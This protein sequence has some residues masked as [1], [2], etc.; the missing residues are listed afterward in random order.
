MSLALAPRFPAMTQQSAKPVGLSMDG[1]LVVAYAALLPIQIEIAVDFRVAPADLCVLL[2]ALPLTV[3]LR[4]RTKAWSFWHMGILLTFAVGS[5]LAILASGGLSRYLFVNKDLGLLL[6]F[7]TYMVVTSAI[8]EWKQ[9]RLVLQVFVWSVVLQNLVGIAEFLISY[10][11]GVD[12]YFTAYGN[13]RFAGMLLD[14]NANGG[15]LILSLLLCEATSRGPTALVRGW[16]LAFCRLTL[17]LGILLSFSRTAWVSLAIAWLFLLFLLPTRIAV[18]IRAVLAGA[19]ALI[20]GM[21]LAGD[22]FVLYFREMA[23][24][25]ESGRA[26]GELMEKAL[27]HFAHNPVWGGGLGNFIETEGTIVHNTPLWFLADFGLIGLAMFVGFMAWFVIKAWDARRLAPYSEKIVVQAL[28]I[29]HIAML[30]LGMGIEAFYQ[31]H[32]WL[33][34]ALIASS[35]H[36]ATRR[37]YLIE[38]ALSA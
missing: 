28:L 24:R 11:F 12:T 8:T 20:L 29:G 16:W 36:I 33:V 32:W 9:V 4:Y 15:L 31:R 21:L 37:K 14:P 2:A 30:S 13:R 1:I 26:R 19:A 7:L 27:S 34:M 3:R 18:A 10:F 25:P 5:F 38:R 6:L 35:Y 22:Q 17:G 23:L